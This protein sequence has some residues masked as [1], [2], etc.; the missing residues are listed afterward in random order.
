MPD[1]NFQPGQRV[2]HPDFGEGVVVGTSPGGYLRAFFATGERQIHADAVRIAQSRTEQILANV[3]DGADR[4]L[5]AWL[6]VEAHALKSVFHGLVKRWSRNASFASVLRASS[7]MF[8]ANA[9]T[10]RKRSHGQSYGGRSCKT[11]ESSKNCWN[12]TRKKVCRKPTC[13]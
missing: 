6:H 12:T 4:L 1:V 11:C 8:A 5:T 3:S 9:S 10:S 13:R 7:S 2:I